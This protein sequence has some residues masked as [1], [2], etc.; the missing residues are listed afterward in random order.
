MAQ[1]APRAVDPRLIA[2]ELQLEMSSPRRTLYFHGESMRPLLV[3]GDEVVVE[4]VAWDEIRI[5]DVV[6]YRYLDRFPTRRVMRKTA[7]G[8]LLWCDN[9]PDRRF[10]CGRDDFL[11]R[12]VARRRGGAWLSASSGTWV[13]AR[14][15]ARGRWEW[16]H[17]R[18]VTLPRQ[19]YRMR[20]ALGRVLRAAGILPPLRPR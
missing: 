11:G 4:P 7:D 20:V 1:R 9:W 6:T 5:G 18:A 13:R 8:L 3:E 12:V 15:L 17:A 19:L 10:A 14:L 16:R 2:K